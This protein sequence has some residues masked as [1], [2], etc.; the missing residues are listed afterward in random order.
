MH[1]IF[2]NLGY[3]MYMNKLNKQSDLKGVLICLY[4]AD[5]ATLKTMFLGPFFPLRA[6]CFF[7]NGKD[8]YV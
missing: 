3:Q 8:K 2:N 1:L 4:M 6:V 7:S 5:P